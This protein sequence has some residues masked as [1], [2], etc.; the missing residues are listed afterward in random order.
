M[1]IRRQHLA[2]A[3]KA[4]AGSTRARLWHGVAAPPGAAAAGS[5]PSAPGT[6]FPVI[7]RHGQGGHLSSTTGRVEPYRPVDRRPWGRQT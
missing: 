4:S 7:R 2:A 6:P 5:R 1:P 3:A